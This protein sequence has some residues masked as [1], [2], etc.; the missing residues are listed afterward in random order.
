MG[1]FP[2]PAEARGAQVPRGERR[3]DAVALLPEPL[4]SDLRADAV[5]AERRDDVDVQVPG[6]L[7]IELDPEA[8]LARLDLPAL[9]QDDLRM[10]AARV[11]V[12][13]ELVVVLLV[14]RLGQRRQRGG[15]EWVSER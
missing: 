9:R 11:V 2:G 10:R 4:P 13:D 6:R 1:V 12:E 7:T 15:L 5:S 8:D 3:L 14:A